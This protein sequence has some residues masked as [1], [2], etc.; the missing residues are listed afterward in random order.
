MFKKDRNV[1]GRRI[2][3]HSI[4]IALITTI[5]LSLIQFWLDYK[6]IVGSVENTFSHVAEI[7]AEGLATALW[8]YSMPEIKAISNGIYNH[9]D[10]SYVEVRENDK[11]IISHGTRLDAGF[12]DEAITLEYANDGSL[13]HIGTLYIQAS[14]AEVYKGIA[15]NIARIL[16]YQAVFVLVLTVIYQILIDRRITRYLVKAVDELNAYDLY[17]LERP[18]NI[19]KR[20]TGDEIDQL[21]RAFNDMRHRLFESAQQRSESERKHTMLLGNLPGM[22][23]RC[24]NDREWTMEI[25]SAGCYDLT[26]YKPEELIDNCVLS[27]N[28]LILEDDREY[29]WETIQTQIKENLSF[30][31]T[32]QIKT[33][34]GQ[35]RW[36]WERGA[37]VFA[38]DHQLVAIEGFI[39]DVT[40]K[41]QQERDLEVIAQVSKALRSV[42]TR[43]LVLSTLVDQIAGL[44]KAEG[45]LIELID[46][47]SGDAVVEAA[48]GIYSTYLGYRVPQGSGLNEYIRQSGNSYI[49]NDVFSDPKYQELS[50]KSDCKASGG[51]P[52]I[53]QENL[54]GYIWITKNSP[55]ADSAIK[56]MNSIADIAANAIRRIDLHEQTQHR[57]LQL[58]GLRK[59]DTAINSNIDLANILDLF[60]D[61]S[62]HLLQVDSVRIMEY[63]SDSGMVTYLAGRG[64]STTAYMEPRILESTSEIG[65]ELLQLRTVQINDLNKYQISDEARELAKTE[66]ILS[67]FIVPLAIKNELRG[68]LQVLLKKPFYPT[69]DWINFLETLA[70][71]AAIAIN[72][73]AMWKN[74]EQRNLDLQIA[75][76]ETLEGWSNALDL[77][78]HE[79]EHH[80]RRVVELTVRLAQEME[81]TGEDLVNVRRGALLHDMGKIGVPDSIL[82]KPGKLTPEEW[83]I[84]RQHP[85][86]AY[87][88]LYPISYLRQA[89]DIPYCHHEKWDGS[90]YPRG[91]KGEEIPLAAR[92]FAVVDVWD[93]MT[94]DRYYRPAISEQ[95]TIE[96]IRQNSGKHFD[97]AVV[98]L[99]LRMK[100]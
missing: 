9:P 90:G 57:L 6:S 21:T 67:I 55:I 59:I 61:E 87:N 22:A 43:S 70:G 51:V 44:L 71:Q 69:G 4:L 20:D 41:K 62:I 86:N 79:T 26:G 91:I 1:I 12:L 28:D 85:V 3:R 100:K 53:S 80:T 95:E 40:E 36:V 83:E 32:Y 13:I 73:S 23:Y 50:I 75:Y 24:K 47:E 56:T 82:T 74:L 5:V 2:F 31:L 33:K 68:F 14:S 92:L 72:D 8:N 45:V 35:L 29:V 7:Q 58:T 94:S 11:V 89:L 25:I 64:F 76:D 78:D 66:K 38:V 30:E 52:M 54:I 63:D 16:I 19:G 10:I 60:L 15:A 81:I 27:Y 65:K 84:M 97:P 98:E 42:E 93:A 34:S 96:Y 99:F 77:R 48:G 37:G 49:N 39:S 17:T 88:L 18:L 46:N